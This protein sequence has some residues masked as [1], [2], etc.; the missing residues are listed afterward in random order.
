[1]PKLYCAHREK[2]LFSLQFCPRNSGLVILL[3]FLFFSWPPVTTAQQET[4]LPEVIVTATRTPENIETVSSSVTVIMGKKLRE[5]GQDILEALRFVPGFTVTQTGARGSNTS[6]FTR[7]SE[8][9]HN[10]VL[11]DGIKVNNA[12]GFFNFADMSTDNIDRIEILRGPQSALYGADAMASVI[13][14]FTRKGRGLPTADAYIRGGSFA[15]IEGGGSVQFGYKNFGL[16]AAV[17]A[18]QT[19]GFLDINNNY[20][21][22]VVSMMADYRVGEWLK[23]Q[24]ST[25][26]SDSRFSYPTGS[27]GDRFDPLDPN[28][29]AETK[30][31]MASPRVEGHVFP[32]W[33]QVL[34]IG[35]NREKRNSADP[36]DVGIDNF[37]SYHS[38]T[39][40]ERITANFLSH[41]GPWRTAS[42]E[43]LSTLEFAVEH[44]SFESNSTSEYLGVTTITRA[45]FNRTNYSFFS[46]IQLK[47]FERLFITP[48][49]RFTKNEKFGDSIDPKVS[50]TYYL[51]RLGTKLRAGYSEGI[52]SPSFL[53]VFGGSG[54]VGNPSLRPEKSRGFEIGINQKFLEKKIL[55]ETTF[56]HNRFK[57]LISYLSG[58]G[59]NYFNIQEVVA[60]GVEATATIQ[61]GYGVTV[62]GSYTYTKTEVV[63]AGSGGGAAFT[64]GKEV[65]RR[66]KHRG[67]LRLGYSYKDFTGH[68]SALLVGDAKDVNFSESP[69]TRVTLKNY[70]RLDL[71][72]SYRIP[73]RINIVRNVYLEFVTK[74]LLNQSYEEVFGFS[75]PGT[76][77]LGGL[78]LEF[79]SQETK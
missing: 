57:D 24:F 23:F 52:K 19:D 71:N 18:T 1:M 27:S 69:A 47:L 78:R 35:Y 32:W 67:T 61:P 51:R 6:V 66:P 62:D 14:I 77:I 50:A 28:Q 15:T 74:N 63:K 8:S 30:R 9:D 54:T 5:S 72:L 16:S 13:Q 20:H 42:A 64:K 55:I 39:L 10:L 44:E 68:I 73:W 59:P 41:F 40:E 12:G 56:F 60:K 36:A 37:G 31:V 79:G 43:I 48:G 65:I 21:N 45:D 29:Y 46:Q 26:C 53:E 17:G 76:E 22:V 7:G 49:V 38:N 2:G 11:I 34:Q 25:R 70:H 3:A 75:T 58:D 33:K 4:A